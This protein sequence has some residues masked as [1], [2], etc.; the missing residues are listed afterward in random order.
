MIN[1]INILDKTAAATKIVCPTL[2]LYSYMLRQGF[3]ETDQTLNRRRK[4]FN[5]NLEKIAAILKT[6][7][8]ETA[9]NFLKLLPPEEEL[10][11]PFGT[12]L[13][14]TNV[15]DEC[16]KPN[17]D[18][19]Y[20]KTGLIHSRLAVR[21]LNDT[22]FLR[23]TRYLPSALGER[24]LDSF[25]KL[26]EGVNNL[27]IELGQTAILAGILNGEYSKEEKRAIA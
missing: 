10:M 14:L 17:S 7:T 16:L 26:A 3:N 24:S 13:D 25:E 12:V 6:S 8:C 21:C 15:P 1:P 19:L 11:A 18:R 4:L 22:Y 20:F 2:H 23:L 27:Q 9:A 5:D